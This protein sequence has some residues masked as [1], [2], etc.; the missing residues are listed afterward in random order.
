[1]LQWRNPF[2]FAWLYRWPPSLQI[3]IRTSAKGE[4]KK[5][6]LR[7]GPD[8][9]SRSAEAHGSN[10]YR[11]NRGPRLRGQDGDHQNA[12]DL[13]SRLGYESP[14]VGIIAARRGLNDDLDSVSDAISLKKPSRKEN[15][16]DVVLL[17][18][19]S[20]SDFFLGTEGFLEGFD[21]WT[22]PGSRISCLSTIWNSEISL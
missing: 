3:L 2:R 15:L 22:I 17:M 21:R 13:F 19:F 14:Q 6:D 20:L 9:V 8:A 11:H 7:G 16:P 12:A 5:A 10:G 18:D 1:L 4:N